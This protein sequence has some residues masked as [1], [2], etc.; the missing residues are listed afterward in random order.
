[1]VAKM[2][3]PGF[4]RVQLL[5]ICEILIDELS[6]EDKSQFQENSS[7]LDVALHSRRSLRFKFRGRAVG[8]VFRVCPVAVV[9][10][11]GLPGL[12]AVPTARSP[13]AAEGA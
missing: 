3:L 6:T 9:F 1:M 7:L 13:D 11:P 8:T 2:V 10:W 4:V 12:C 5:K